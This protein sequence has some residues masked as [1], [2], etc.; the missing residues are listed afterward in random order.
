M[1]K[2]LLFLWLLFL[3]PLAALKAQS[4]ADLL[5]Q[6]MRQEEQLNE[7][8][9]F[10]TLRQVLRINPSNYQALWKAS[11]LC[12]RLGKRQPATRQQQ[13]Y[14]QLGRAY[15]LRAIQTRPQGADGYYTLAVAMGRMAMTQ[16]GRERVQTVKEIRSNIEKALAF[17]PGHGRAW[18][19]LGKWHY[20]VSNLGMFEKA[21][22]KLIYGGLP[23]S[24]LRESI[25]AYEKARTLEPG[26]ALNFLE[27]AKAYHRDEQEEKAL[28]LLRH[29]LRLPNRTGDDAHIKNEAAKLLKRWSE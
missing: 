21:A 19:V 28:E 5:E 24:S 11:E 23:A 8:A 3:F 25:K 20:E 22:L 14:Y 2:P 16:S 15:A 9:A 18:H 1:N 27:L 17:Q 6:A 10:E 29:L 13:E 26:F 12:S 4:E 7:A